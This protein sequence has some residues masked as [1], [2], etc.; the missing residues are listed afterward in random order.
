MN[1]TASLQ[2]Q[3]G[4]SHHQLPCN[5]CWSTYSVKHIDPDASAVKCIVVFAIQREPWL[6]KAVQIPRGLLLVLQGRI[7]GH[8][9]IECDRCH[10]GILLRGLELG[11]SKLQ[12][13]THVR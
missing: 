6:V 9:P 10:L 13:G 3:H 7:C 8:I 2:G 1:A 11:G 4:D 5:E 12:L